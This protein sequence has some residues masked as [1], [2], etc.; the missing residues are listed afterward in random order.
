MENKIDFKKKWEAPSLE[1][2]EV[3]RTLGGIIN[4]SE[5]GISGGS[6]GS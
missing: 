6:S 4:G 5:N 3:V 2:L 1:K